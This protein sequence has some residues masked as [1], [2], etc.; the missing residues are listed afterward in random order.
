MDIDE[1]KAAAL[2]ALRERMPDVEYIGIDEPRQYEGA[3]YID[4]LS[5]IGVTKRIAGRLA[6]CGVDMAANAWMELPTETIVNW[7]ATIVTEEFEFASE[8]PEDYE[9][10]Q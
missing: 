10:W 9:E 5:R 6:Y 4:G 7:I 1:R 3:A 2:S 8:N